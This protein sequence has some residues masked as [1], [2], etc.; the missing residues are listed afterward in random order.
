[1]DIGLLLTLVKYGFCGLIASFLGVLV[2]WFLR[3]DFADKLITKFY[4]KFSRDELKKFLL[5]AII[6]G[7]VIGVYWLLRP[8]KDGIFCKMSGSL[9]IPYAK[10]LSLV[11]VFPLVMIYSKL[12]DK[13]PRHRVFYALCAIY[14]TLALMFAYFFSSSTLGLANTEVITLVGGKTDTQHVLLLGRMIGWAWYIFIESFGS[15]IV[16]LFWSFNADITSPDSAKKGYPI[17]GMGGQLGGVMGPL[18]IATQAKNLGAHT[19]AFIAGIWIFCIALMIK[20][21]VTI[22][23]KEQL[24]GYQSA[25]EANSPKVKKEETGFTEGLKLMLS[26]PYLLGIFAVIS[27]YEVV[28]TIFDFQ[29]KSLSASKFASAGELSAYLGEYGVWTNGIAL[30]CMLLGINVI[31]RKLGLTTALVLMPI[32]VALGVGALFLSSTLEPEIALTVAFWVMVLS[33]SI[34]YALNQPTKEQLYIP[35]T[36]DTKYK[37]KAWTEMF[38]SRSSKAAGSVVNVIKKY[39]TPDMFV[40]VSSL[41]SLGLIG[42]WIAVAFYLGKT[43]KKAV[44]ENKV[45]C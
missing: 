37:A 26:K 16:A 4:G 19:M 3:V 27:L 43:H 14:G 20:I 42:I 2:L 15:I 1:M 12:V 36:R 45:V 38:G 8:I 29:L 21:F 10:M 9:N 34:N 22:T 31:A 5:L 41:F 39:V 33:K 44:T 18:L 17:I 35:T 24:V 25:E 32:L 11:I 28:V 13:F 6:F 30:V 7:F 40:I 23:P